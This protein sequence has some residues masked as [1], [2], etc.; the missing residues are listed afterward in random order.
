MTACT[1]QWD[2]SHSHKHFDPMRLWGTSIY[3]YVHLV[4]PLGGF[5]TQ[6]FVS[7][8]AVSQNEWMRL[9]VYGNEKSGCK[10][11]LLHFCCVSFQHVSN[12]RGVKVGWGL[13][14]GTATKPP[15]QTVQPLREKTHSALVP[16]AISMR[17]ELKMWASKCRPFTST[18]VKW[19]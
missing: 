4:Y 2:C 12:L 7:L 6:A 17:L 5:L 3:L 9:I 11:S 18:F 15:E 10:H 16:F 14:Y 19:I 13:H 1:I 8:S